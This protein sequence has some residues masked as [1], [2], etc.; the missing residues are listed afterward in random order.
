[1]KHS[2][3]ASQ[4][5]LNARAGFQRAEPFGRGAS[6]AVRKVLTAEKHRHRLNTYLCTD[7]TPF[8]IH[9]S[10]FTIH[11]SLFRVTS[12]EAGRTRL[13]FGSHAAK[14]KL[15]RTSPIEIPCII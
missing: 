9:D 5:E 11:F 3:D 1:M 7:L 15:F 4:R 14:Q 6:A 13:R 12:I 8:T 10:F 2:D